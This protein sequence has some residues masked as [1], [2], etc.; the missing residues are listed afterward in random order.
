MPRTLPWLKT[1]LVPSNASRVSP[2]SQTTKRGRDAVQNN[3][4]SIQS[5]E[6]R[7]ASKSPSTSPLPPPPDV[8]FMH[9]GDSQWRMVEDESVS[10]SIVVDSFIEFYS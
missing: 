1:D 2:V 9:D 10:E 5:K 4:D 7:R 3:Q 8:E 6:L